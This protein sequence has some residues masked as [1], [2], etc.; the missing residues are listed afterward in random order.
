[1]FNTVTGGWGSGVS[2]LAKYSPPHTGVPR[3]REP[4]TPW[5][6][7]VAGPRRY[8]LF[9][10]T[11]SSSFCSLV[12]QQEIQSKRIKDKELD[13]PLLPYSIRRRT[14]G[15]FA[16]RADIW[17][18][19]S[20]SMLSAPKCFIRIASHTSGGLGV[21]EWRLILKRGKNEIQA[22]QQS[23]QGVFVCNH[24]SLVINK[25]PSKI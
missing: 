15:G 6:P 12:K 10:L 3:P 5:D 1:M 22:E 24:A 7:T 17:V 8:S 21:F 2:I 23:P 19:Y 13:N 14:R 20:P 18:A 25:S 11:R 16:R 9:W 4:P